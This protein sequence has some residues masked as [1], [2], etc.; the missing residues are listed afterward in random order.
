MA[1]FYVTTPIYYVN[2]APHIGHAY[3][4]IVADVFARHYR[5]RGD[6]VFFLTGTDEHGLKVQRAAEEQGI[7]PQELVDTNSAKFRDLFAKLELT[8][9]RFV[10]TTEADHKDAVVEMVRRMK[11]AGDIYLDTYAGWY[12]ASDEA[13]YSED[14]IEDGKAIESGSAVEWVE[15]KS[16]FFRLSKYEQPLIE[17]YNSQDIPVRPKARRN[18]IA[19]FVEGGL[20][21]LS[22]SRTTFNWGIEFPEDPEHVL[23]V[24]VDALTNYITGIGGFD[25]KGE[26]AKFWPAD[27]H[28]IGKDILRFHAVYWPAFLMSAGVELPKQ[29]FAH[30]WWTVD[31]QKMSKSRGNWVDAFE[32]V[33]Q[34]PLDL[35]RY[36]MIREIP[37]GSDG[38]FVQERIVERNNSELADN[39]GNLVNRTTKMMQGFLGGT[40]PKSV[41]TDVEADV[42]LREC[43][44]KTLT[45]VR[46]SMDKRE[47][48]H[49]LESI[50]HLGNELNQYIQ[51]TQPWKAKKEGDSER[52]EQ[53]LYHALEGIRW[54]A[55][56]V[57]AFVPDAAA[58]ILVAFGLDPVEGARLDALQWGGLPAG[59]TI[60]TPDVLFE[61]IEL[62]V[63][64]PVEK[65]PKKKS[66]KKGDKKMNKD[67]AEG[68]GLIE[69]GDFLKVKMAVGRILSAER[70]DGAD[71]LLKLSADVGEDA[72]RTIVAGLALAFEPEDLVNKQVAMVVNLKPAK[73]F[74]IKS[75]AMVLAVKD[76]DGG[77]ELAFFSDNIVPGTQIS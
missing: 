20:N 32:L 53:I 33:E 15:E 60:T 51:S 50:M 7:S 6:E 13:Y 23:Y 68:S 57:Q 46:D 24:W 59:N 56:L 61:K 74:G 34:Y 35:L 62:D 67:D 29:V 11:A 52:V 18:E 30:G 31:G 72:P 1:D 42:S 2:G 45:E 64:K 41:E 21:D 54:M 3:T 12:S 71:K 63:P 69:F 37:L 38:N 65:E 48:H 14:E 49:A 16:Y 70:V 19:A 43:A 5:Q 36:F 26:P 66:K 55:V 47:P 8:H 73:L 75:E 25:E 10:R 17:W 44:A 40:V 39:L 4:T 27:L 28:L 58:K 9:D 76:A 22:I 77:L